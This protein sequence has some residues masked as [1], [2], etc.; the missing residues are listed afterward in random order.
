M[1]YGYVSNGLADHRIEDALEL[2][3][4]NGYDGVALTL[5][6]VHFDPLA[7]RLRAR[8][9]RL[10]LRLEALGLAC[11]IETGARFVLDPRRKHFPTLVS[12]GRERR[13]DLLCRAVDVAAELGAPV[14][15]LWSGAAPGDI[16][17]GRAWDLLIDGL[18]RVLE[19]A[20][21]AG[22]TLAF[23][24]EPGMLV[25]RLSDYEL[26][27]QRLGGPDAL[28]LTLD[29]GH[30][31]C[32]EPESP[33]DCIRRAGARLA[34]VHIEDMVRGVHEHLM[35]GEGELELPAA[36]AALEEIGYDGLVA[37]E[38]SRH[39]HRA[40]EVVP[41]AMTALREAMVPA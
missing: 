7:P 39:A 13:V 9:G 14:V 15:S 17:P 26:L 16:D 25:E 27:E 2:L 11:V 21:R 24:P 1:R 29:I 20:A 19:H 32:L 6:H 12:D 28:A 10:R 38:L 40:H 23:E 35:F 4:E 31:V 34:H 33:A 37:V 3:A 8:A 41:A 22:V 36:L 30:C 5:D 18:G